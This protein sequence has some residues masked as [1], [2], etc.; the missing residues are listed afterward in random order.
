MPE[1]ERLFHG[2]LCR[3][4]ECGIWTINQTD[5]TTEYACTNILELLILNRI[6]FLF[7]NNISYVPGTLI[8]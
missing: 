1:F 4:T 2:V 6:N 5:D 7:I 8:Y 3:N